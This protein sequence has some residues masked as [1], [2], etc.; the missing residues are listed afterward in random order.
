MIMETQTSLS[1]RIEWNKEQKRY[2]LRRKTSIWNYDPIEQRKLGNNPLSRKTTWHELNVLP[3]GRRPEKK[4]LIPIIIKKLATDRET[5]ET[6]TAYFSQTLEVSILSDS[7]YA[8]LY[9]VEN[10]GK[11]YLNC[12]SS[13]QCCPIALSGA[14]Q[15]GTEKKFAGKEV[16]LTDEQALKMIDEGSPVYE[17]VGSEYRILI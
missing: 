12:I 6:L 17:K 10:M 14:N 1:E 11:A 15:T 13:G 8:N 9:L 16:R 5:L 4:V 3:Q 2:M 7:K